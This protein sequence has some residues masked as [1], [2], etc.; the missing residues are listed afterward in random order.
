MRNAKTEVL[1]ALENKAELKCAKITKGYDNEEKPTY[2]LKLGYSKEDLE[3][4]L[5]LLSFDYDSSYG[6]QELFGT[7]W[8]KDGTWLSRGEYDGSEWWEHNTLPEVT[9]DLI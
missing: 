7:L 1:E 6:G 5:N 8:L 2:R 3:T 4:F 9:D